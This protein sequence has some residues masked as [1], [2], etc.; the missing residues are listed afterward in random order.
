MAARAIE[1]ASVPGPEGAISLANLV[2]QRSGLGDSDAL[3]IDAVAAS[4]RARVTE[5]ELGAA[6]RGPE[7]ILIPLPEDR[8]GISVDPTPPDGWGELEPRRRSD[9]KRHR[10]RFRVGHE[11]GHTLFYSRRS[12]DTPRR[13]VPD[14][15]RQES[16]CDQF[17]RNLLVPHRIAAMASPGLEGLI[18]L[19]ETFDVSL[20]LA[21]RAM[22]AAQPNLRLALWF[23]S[24]ANRWTSQWASPQLATET[25][26]HC[27]VEASFL[28]ARS[29]LVV[30]YRSLD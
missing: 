3:D 6:E 16:F 29:Q 20:Q 17:S 8:F 1:V 30:F 24:P 9:L 14:S 12:S 7:A 5:R 25:G 19:L 21:A 10:V 22:V 4:L 13:L 26:S 27:E 15:N 18:E 23:R 11:L 28:D 2:R